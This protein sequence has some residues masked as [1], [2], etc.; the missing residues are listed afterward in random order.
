MKLLVSGY[1]VAEDKGIFEYTLSD[2]G[3]L[4]YVNTFMA[5]GI[6]THIEVY[7]SYWFVSMKPDAVATGGV[8]VFKEGVLLTEMLIPNMSYAHL[9]VD[10]PYIYAIS[11]HEGHT[12]SFMFE[13]NQIKLISDI[14]HEGSSCN[15][16]RQDKPHP[17][18]VGMTLDKKYVYCVDLGLDKIIYY[19][20]EQGILEHT[21]SIDVDAGSGPRQMVFSKKNNLAYLVTEI[22]N[23]VQVYEYNEKEMIK[24]QSLSTIP[25]DF[26]GVNHLAAVKLNEN[27]NLL[28][29]SNRGHDSIALYE[30]RDDG[31]LSFKKKFFCGKTPR[32]ASFIGEQFIAVACQD[33]DVLEIFEI[34][35]TEINKIDEIY[36]K[37]PVDIAY[38]ESLK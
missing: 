16:I 33:S 13:N 10:F 32:D 23:T 9:C 15:P 3:L 25:S 6:A 21:F 18:Y 1:G 27:E 19:K 26:N 24:L 29:V 28:L 34:E 38:F 35:E 14:I 36:V 5:S 31:L 30:V 17:H 8:A 11:Y 4:Q 22:A 37:Q 2:E 7:K 12:T 20:H